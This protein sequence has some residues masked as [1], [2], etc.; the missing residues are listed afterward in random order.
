MKSRFYI[1]LVD[2]THNLVFIASYYIYSK[3]LMF[4][5]MIVIESGILFKNHVSC[6]LF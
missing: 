2:V 6:N 1:S 3:L 4:K 5:L